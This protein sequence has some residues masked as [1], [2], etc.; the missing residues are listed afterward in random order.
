MFSKFDDS[1]EDIKWAAS[2]AVGRIAARNIA[3][4]LPMIITRLK[5]APSH[6]YLL[7]KALKEVLWRPEYFVCSCLRF[8]TGNRS[9]RRPGR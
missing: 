4:V 1:H 9:S 7:L 5:R 6:R 2:K 8:F 3:A